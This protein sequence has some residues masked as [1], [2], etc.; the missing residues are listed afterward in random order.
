MFYTNAENTNKI[1]ELKVRRHLKPLDALV[2][3]EVYL[4]TGKSF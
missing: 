3:A 1:D 2:V 4:K